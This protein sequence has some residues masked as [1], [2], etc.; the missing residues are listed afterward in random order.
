MAHSVSTLW[1]TVWSQCGDHTVIRLWVTV[2]AH[3]ATEWKG[4]PI[5]RSGMTMWTQCDALCEP[6]CASYGVHSVNYDGDHAVIHHIVHHTV[7]FTTYSTTLWYSPYIPPL[8]GIY[9]SLHHRF[10]MNIHVR[11]FY[12]QKKQILNIIHRSLSHGQEVP[13]GLF[14]YGKITKRDM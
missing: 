6:Q 1:I 14:G 3:C 11:S 2:W 5:Y 13:N 7:I 12:L 4:V 8:C 10:L 9:H